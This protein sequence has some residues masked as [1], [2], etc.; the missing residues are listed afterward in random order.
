MNRPDGLDLYGQLAQA[1]A[2][3]P[4][5]AGEMTG[6]YETKMT[7]S[8]DEEGPAGLLGGLGL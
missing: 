2:A 7:E 8:V 6:T 4:P 1:P 3:A 5:E